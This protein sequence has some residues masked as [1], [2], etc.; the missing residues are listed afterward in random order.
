MNCRDIT[1]LVLTHNEAPNIARCLSRLT[2]AT[3]VLVVDSG[4][5]D[6][7]LSV[8]AEFP[9]VRVAFRKFD[10]FASQCN[11]GLSLVTSEWVL[12]IDADYILC[13]EFEGT[14]RGLSGNVD[15]YSMGFRYLVH[16]QPLRGSLYPPRTVLYRV[17]KA[18]YEDIGHGHRVKI[19]GLTESADYIVD[20]DDRKSLARWL[21]SQCRYAV[22]EADHL[23][24]ASP[25]SLKL[26][27]R[28]RLRIW[29]AVPAVLFYVLIWRRGLFDGWPGVFYA[30]Q[31]AYAELLLSLELLDRKLRREGSSA[32]HCQ[33]PDHS[34][35]APSL[36]RRECSHP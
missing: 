26:A 27:D 31:R 15:G 11:F 13:K 20:H 14:C 24:T 5:T 16:G 1:V 7:T 30:G 23:T 34:R 4:S 36:A 12:S 8:C 9:N 18:R 2:W 3:T 33:S 32:G 22:R 29:P 17:K 21:A 10:S 25:A 6:E 19:D 28:V 35:Q